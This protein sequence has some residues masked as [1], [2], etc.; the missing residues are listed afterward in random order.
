MA[1]QLIRA[2]M[3]MQQNDEAVVHARNWIQSY[4]SSHNSALAWHVLAEA[5]LQD[6]DP[7][8]ALWIAL[9]PIALQQGHP[10]AYLE[11]C[12]RTAIQSA[13]ALKLSGYAQSL[14]NDLMTLYPNRVPDYPFSDLEST[15]SDDAFPLLPSFNE[16]SPAFV[17]LLKTRLSP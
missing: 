6:G 10:S 14:R 17:N 8:S 11:R 3:A 13:F 4:S 9:Q 7:E 2:A 5:R 12:Y 1:K 15:V 16:P